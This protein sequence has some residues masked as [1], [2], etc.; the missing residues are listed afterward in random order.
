M[1][2]NIA[3]GNWKMNKSIQE[4]VSFMDSFL[5][6]DFP[7]DVNVI[8]GVP[9]VSIFALSQQIKKSGKSINIAA[10][11]CHQNTSGA[12]TGELSPSMIK[13]AGADYVILGHSER[14]AYFGESDDL[15]L[16]K[17]K[18]ALAEGLKVIFCCGEPL[19]V[20]KEMTHIEYV[21][22]QINQSILKLNESDMQNIIIAYEPIWAIGTGETASSQQAQEMHAEIRNVIATEYGENIAAKTSILYGGSV[23]P[24]NAKELFSQPDVDGGLVGGASLDAGSFAEIVF[25]F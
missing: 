12:F 8:L 23:K 10:Q 18:A 5:S 22:N 15:I 17:S 6:N 11:N 3:A 24:A 13:G 7:E 19:E 25:S 4:G 1:S 9:S 21:T 14:R 20:R 16:E 2:R